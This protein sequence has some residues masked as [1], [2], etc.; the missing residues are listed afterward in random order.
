MLLIV[1]Y[2]PSPLSAMAYLRTITLWSKGPWIDGAC[3]SLAVATLFYALIFVTLIFRRCTL[4]PAAAGVLTVLS[5]AYTALHV[6][7]V[8]VLMAAFT[9][10]LL[11]EPAVRTLLKSVLSVVGRWVA[12]I[13][14]F[15]F[16][17]RP[18]DTI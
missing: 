6:A 14:P 1:A 10:A 12:G 8:I 3:W 11:A 18:S 13:R 2:E 7:I 4:L 9:V 15:G 5:A 17:F 16:M